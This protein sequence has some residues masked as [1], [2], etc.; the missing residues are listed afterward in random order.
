MPVLPHNFPTLR[1]NGRAGHRPSVIVL[2][3]GMSNG[4]VPGPGQLLAEQRAN[5]E[6]SSGCNSTVAVSAAPIAQDLYKWADEILGQLTRRG[7][8][9]PKL[10][11]AEALGIHSDVRW[12]GNTAT[13]RNTPRHRVIARFARERLWDQ[14]WSLNW[15]CVQESAF[16]NVGIRRDGKDEEMPWPNVFSS[17]VTVDQLAD[18]GAPYIVKIVKPHGCVMALVNSREAWNNGD[19]P[20][21]ISLAERFLITASE[22]GG[23]VARPGAD[24]IQHFVFDNLSAELQKYPLITAGWSVSEPYLIDHIEAHVKPVL[25]ERN[26]LARDE[27]SVVDI[28]FNPCG[29]TRLAACYGRDKT[30]A[31]IPI[32]QAAFDLDH[33]FLW[34][35]SLY[36]VS[37]LQSWVRNDDKVSF[38]ELSSKVQQPPST[39]AF[40]VDWVDNFL[41]VWVRLCWHCRLVGG[42]DRNGHPVETDRI[43][44]ESRDEH[45]PWRLENT[46]RPELESATRLLVTLYSSPTGTDW[47]FERFPGGLFHDNQLIV[48]LP[49][50]ATAPT[51]DLR[52]LRALVD[53]IKVGGDISK[54]KVLF[55][56]PD[57]SVSVPEKIRLESKEFLAKELALARFARGRDI[58]EIGLED[59]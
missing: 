45:I 21:S 57:P 19:R 24:G 41:P 53:S 47:D 30:S 12:R 22:L 29:H 44:L 9:N 3:S 15:D 51:N 39:P 1:N 26:D 35:Q 52:G 20:R 4:L 48:P 18:M 2:G 31:H 23:L 14:I 7:E 16:E 58:E 32:D 37:C 46:P 13:Q 36:A 25:Q 27:L 8:G 10:I 56:V 43:Y 54:L 17:F 50:W 5:A 42:F 28:E 34:L 49:A 55:L 59:L 40:V 38:G 33:F 6:S 11:L